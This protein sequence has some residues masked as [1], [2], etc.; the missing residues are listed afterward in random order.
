MYLND[1]LYSRKI[2]IIFLAYVEY[3]NDNLYSR[4]I[5]I[6]LVYVVLDQRLV[7]IFA[8]CASHTIGNV[9]FLLTQ[10]VDVGI[11]CCLCSK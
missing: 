4:K 1:N 2:E 8:E 6:F 9:L 10:Q 7:T 5:E 11:H 3:L